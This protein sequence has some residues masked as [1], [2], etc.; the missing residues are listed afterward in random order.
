MQDSLLRRFLR[1]AE[2]KEA[3]GETARL[4]VMTARSGSMEMKNNLLQAKADQ[5]VTGR[6]LRIILLSDYDI[7]PADT[8]LVPVGSGF[9]SIALNA[10]LNPA[11]GYYGQQ[12][13]IASAERKL[14]QNNLLPGL[15]VGYFNQSIVGN[16]E[17]DGVERYL[18]PSF[19]FTGVTAG[20]TVPLWIPAYTARNKA[21]KL[22]ER[23]AQT[24]ADNF[25]LSLQGEYEN[26]LDEL[27]K[28]ALSV[29]YYNEQALPEAEL[30]VKHAT[31]SYFS[32][33][34]NYTA[35][36]ISLEGSLRIRQEALTA[37]NAYNQTV[38]SIEALTGK[39]F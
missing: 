37:V 8:V 32:G 21:A 12:A 22:K 1:A 33:E 24:E 39:L 5:S 34:I 10:G 26:L 7:I 25:Y 9:D 6:K 11:L 27:K 23:A 38:I 20:I 28:L 19:R 14:E 16:Q 30:I 2:L 17:I 18:G 35:Y 15:N 31:K 4:E 3:A 36:V 13:V 29:R